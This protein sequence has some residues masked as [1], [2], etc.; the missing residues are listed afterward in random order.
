MPWALISQPLFLYTPP[1]A[2]VLLPLLPSLMVCLPYHA[3]LTPLPRRLSCEGG[4]GY[5]L[6]WILE[7]YGLILDSALVSYPLE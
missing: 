2:W 4:E 6:F 7:G 5:G 1:C 3:R